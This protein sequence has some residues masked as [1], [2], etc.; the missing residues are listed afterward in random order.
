M[1]GITFTLSPPTLWAMSV[2]M[3]ESEATLSSARAA[4]RKAI[5]TLTMPKILF[6]NDNAELTVP[7]K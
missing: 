2:V 4:A 1:M 7:S 3:V 5:E 6:T